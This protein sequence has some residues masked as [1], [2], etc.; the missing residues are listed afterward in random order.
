M[1]RRKLRPGGAGRLLL[2][3]GEVKGEGL[4][5]GRC[6]KYCPGRNLVLDQ[7]WKLSSLLLIFSSL[8]SSE[9]KNQV[10]LN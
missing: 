10:S 6:R 2:S 3:P 1:G 9:T 5:D 7:C 4:G 8:F